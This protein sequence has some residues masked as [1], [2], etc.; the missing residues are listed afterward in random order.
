MASSAYVMHSG[1][2]RDPL[3]YVGRHSNENA[4]RLILFVR[5]FWSGYA[6]HIIGATR[7]IQDL[8]YKSI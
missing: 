1:A 4:T 7:Y 8:A 6:M 2:A 3:L 5:L